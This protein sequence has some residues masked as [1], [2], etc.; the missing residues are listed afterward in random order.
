MVVFDA[1]DVEKSNK[2]FCISVY[3][4]NYEFN[5]SEKDFTNNRKIDKMALMLK[6]RFNCV[7]AVREYLFFAKR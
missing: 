7:D 5:D 4:S 3:L 6:S 2:Q 1:D